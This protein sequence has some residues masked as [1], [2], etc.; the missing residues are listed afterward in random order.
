VVSLCSLPKFLLFLYLSLLHAGRCPWVIVVLPCLRRLFAGLSQR[1]P[2][3]D[4]GKVRTAFVVDSLALETGFLIL[5]TSSLSVSFFQCSVLIHSTG[6]LVVL[7]QQL[8]TPL[9]HLRSSS[10]MLVRSCHTVKDKHS[11]RSLVWRYRSLDFCSVRKHS[12]SS[13]CMFFGDRGFAENRCNIKRSL[14]NWRIYT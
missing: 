3:F 1:G 6:I 5:L 12:C 2:R 13:F 7:S 14:S 11:D 8:A 10:V 4:L 9:T